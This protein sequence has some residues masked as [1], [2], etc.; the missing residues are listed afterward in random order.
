MQTELVRIWE[1]ERRTVLFVTHSIDE[2]I[3]LSDRIIVMTDGSIREEVSVDIERPRTREGLLE[4][5]TA[6]DLRHRL[7]ELL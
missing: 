5:R 4:D 7:L 1:Q 2:A 3:L 6:I